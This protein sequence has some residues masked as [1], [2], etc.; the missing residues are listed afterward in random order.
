MNKQKYIGI[1][2]NPTKNYDGFL[3]ID[4]TRINKESLSLINDISID[5]YTSLLI[6]RFCSKEKN[7]NNLFSIFIFIKLQKK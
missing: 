3:E 6:E 7:G 5:W 2:W 1:R 4:K